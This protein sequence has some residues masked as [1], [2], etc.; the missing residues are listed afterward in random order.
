M[1]E[2]KQRLYEYAVRDAA[3]A[4]VAQGH[5]LAPLTARAT[6][7]DEGD[8]SKIHHVETADPG[9]VV[10]V[11]IPFVPDGATVELRSLVPDADRPYQEWTAQDAGS[12][13]VEPSPAQPHSFSP[14]RR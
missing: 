2:G 5:F 10:R 3:G 13:R 9:S 4:V 12:I 11:A 7:A 14:V 1:L 6:I 8:P